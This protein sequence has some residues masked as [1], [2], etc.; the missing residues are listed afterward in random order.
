M[1]DQVRVLHNW[2]QEKAALDAIIKDARADCETKLAEVL[3]ERGVLEMSI[4]VCES[5]LK[6]E[7]ASFYDGEDKSKVYGVGIREVTKLA[8]SGA[9]AFDWAVAHKLALKL[10]GKTFEKLAKIDPPDFVTITTEPQATIAADLSE[11]LDD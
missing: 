8:Y 6:A 5:E 4:T 10:D 2:R 9:E 1:L 11:Y 7:R 3:A